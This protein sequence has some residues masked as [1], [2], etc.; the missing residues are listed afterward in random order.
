VLEA[1]EDLRGNILDVRHDRAGW[2][3]PVGSVEV[4]VLVELRSEDAGPQIELNLAELGFVVLE[5]ER[6][7][8]VPGR[9][10]G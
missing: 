2:K 1:V 8:A 5:A 6:R 10:G 3:V 7:R 4:E 9:G